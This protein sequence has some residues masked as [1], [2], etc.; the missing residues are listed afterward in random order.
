[1]TVNPIDERFLGAC[2]TALERVGRKLR[3]PDRFG[4]SCPAIAKAGRN[5][6]KRSSILKSR[7]ET[8]NSSRTFSK[9][10]RIFYFRPA[11]AKSCPEFEKVSRLSKKSGNFGKSQTE[12]LIS[13]RKSK[14]PGDFRNF[15]T[16]FSISV[17]L[18]KKTDNFSCF[19][20]TLCCK[21]LGRKSHGHRH[22]G[23]I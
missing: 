7:T 20:T 23:R 22:A 16:A 9:S 19:R 11:F 8:G 17:R 12:I 18:F 14:F 10:D 4:K 13:R 6:K 1:M 5:S 3:F 21:L 15:R 2:P